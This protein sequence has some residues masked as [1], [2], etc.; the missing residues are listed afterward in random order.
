MIEPDQIVATVAATLPRGTSPVCETWSDAV[1]SRYQ[2]TPSP[3]CRGGSRRW[4]PGQIC[5]SVKCQYRCETAYPESPLTRGWFRDLARPMMPP[6]IGREDARAPSGRGV[7]LPGIPHPTAASAG[8]GPAVRVH[9]PVQEGARCRQGRDVGTHPLPCT[10]HARGLAPANQ[11]AAAGLVHLLPPRG[12]QADL[13]VRRPL[14]LLADRRLAPQTTPW[15]ELG[16]P[17]PS[18]PPGVGDQRRG[19]R[20]VPSTRGGP[21][22]L[23]LSGRA[24]PDA[25][26]EHHRGMSTRRAARPVRP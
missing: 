7:R 22:M 1:H 3:T 23:P 25:V 11:P 16:H 15:T 17:V 18:L 13:R 9:L 5:G 14:R 4:K 12:L 8:I 24:D 21:H 26:G 6:R 10:S 2:R 19:S 20:P